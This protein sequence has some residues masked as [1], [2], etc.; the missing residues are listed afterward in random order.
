M[1]QGDINIFSTYRSLSAAATVL[2]VRGGVPSSSIHL[3]AVSVA[4]VRAITN[5]INVSFFSYYC[6]RTVIDLPTTIHVHDTNH[7]VVPKSMQLQT[8]LFQPG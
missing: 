7:H 2:W 4:V 3:M 5:T 6:G 1:Q 8:V